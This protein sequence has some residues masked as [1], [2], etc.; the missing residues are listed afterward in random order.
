MLYSRSRFY[1]ARQIFP[2]DARAENKFFPTENFSSCQHIVSV[3]IF[4]KPH[5]RLLT[6]LGIFIA[7]K[8]KIPPNYSPEMFGV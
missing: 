5:G 3:D 1:K 8:K 7:Y 6:S 4:L 2:A